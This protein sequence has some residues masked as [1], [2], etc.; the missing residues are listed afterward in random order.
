LVIGFRPNELH[1][2]MCD[3]AHRHPI[4]AIRTDDKRCHLDTV[5]NRCRLSAVHSTVR[6]RNSATL[7]PIYLR[8][9]TE[10]AKSPSDLQFSGLEVSSLSANSTMGHAPCDR[11]VLRCGPWLE[12]LFSGGCRSGISSI[13]RVSYLTQRGRSGDTSLVTQLRHQSIMETNRSAVNDLSALQ[14]PGQ[15]S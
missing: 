2:V 6:L 9:D 14:F 5:G 8:V 10:N 4:T 1:T 11:S 13:N 3:G 15:G 7:A 12:L